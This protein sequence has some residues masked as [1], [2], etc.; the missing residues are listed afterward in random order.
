MLPK[1]TQQVASAARFAALIG[2]IAGTHVFAG[3]SEISAVGAVEAADCKAGTLRILGVTFAAT[4]AGASAAI[5]GI[6][7]PLDV[8]YVSVTGT[9]SADGSVVLRGLTSL[10]SGTYVPGATPVYLSG[11]VSK[12]SAGSGDAELSGATV[13]VGTSDLSVGSV[14]EILGTQPAFG[15][16]ILPTI[17]RVIEAIDE[18]VAFASTDSSIGSGTSTRSSIGSGISTNSSIGSGVSTRSSIGS[19]ISTSSSIGSGV[20][21]G[22][23]IG[24]GSNTQ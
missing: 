19:G 9:I 1:A 23:S 12:V 8:H 22:S 13:Y 11:S 6:G 2:L 10:S 21:T 17:V 3:S 16:I 24:S 15:S 18:D 14:V 5:C 4:D 20:S 7:N